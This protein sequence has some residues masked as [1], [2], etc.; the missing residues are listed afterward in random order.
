MKYIYFDFD[1]TL[2][3]S[4]ALGVGIANNL[5]PKYG[6]R[7]VDYNKIDFYRGLSSQELLKEFRVPLLVLPIVAAHIKKDMSLNI[8]QLKPYDDIDILLKELSSKFYIGILTSN[9]VENV[10]RFLKNHNLHQYIS[11][12]RSELQLFGKH[13]ALRKILNS[14]NIEKESLIYVGDETRDIDAT[15]KLNICSIAVTWG[16][17]SR[18]ALEKIKPTFMADKVS[19]ILDF[20]NKVF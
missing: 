11:D 3:N 12:I 7:A 15:K 16:F 8:D 2:A 19:E 1:G 4:F 18:V 14:H 5:A 9:T 10:T 20:V 13:V 17:N 6:Y